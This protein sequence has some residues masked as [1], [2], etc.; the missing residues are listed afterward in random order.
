MFDKRGESKGQSTPDAE[1]SA[2]DG[3]GPAPAWVAELFGQRAGLIGDF[4]EMLAEQGI[5]RGLIGPREVPRIWERHIGNSAVVSQVVPEDASVI[6]VGS[7]A[8]LP[9]IPLA[10]A[11]PDL[12]VVLIEPMLRRTT[13]LQEVVDE[14]G[15]VHVRVV[16]GRAENLVGQERAQLVTSRAVAPLGKLARWC[17]PLVQS[18]GAMIA[19]KGS[20][21]QEEVDRDGQ[22][23]DE[24]GGGPAE[25]IQV[26]SPPLAE[27]TYV[28]RSA[29][30]RDVAPPVTGGGKGRS[31][32][33]GR[34][35]KRSG[36]Q[37]RG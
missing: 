36:G 8:G 27:A 28:V 31:S 2:V 25:V 15:L 29:K 18:G 30:V 4:A 24:A 10:I 19:L 17:F 12:E 5:R 11:R 35:K 34:K 7:G 37:R 26:G 16:R 9:G 21:A 20:T 14:L 1:G 13:W 33:Q 23:I 3:L 32:K 6:D 22:E